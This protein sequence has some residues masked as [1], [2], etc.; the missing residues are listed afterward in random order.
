MGIKIIN[1]LASILCFWLSGATWGA[2][3]GMATTILWAI[4]G[5]VNLI[6][7]GVGK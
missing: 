3:V 5:V 2:G 6:L 4:M 7:I 1:L